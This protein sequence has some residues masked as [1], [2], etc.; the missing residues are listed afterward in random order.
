[1]AIKLSKNNLCVN[2]IVGQKTEKIVVEGDE[3]VP[4]IKPDILSVV[5]TNGNICIYKKEVQDGK[6]KI[7]G[8]INAYVIYIADDEKSSIRALSANLE[9]SRTIDIKECKEN[10]QLEC[11]SQ[12]SNM[13]CRILNGRKISLRAIMDMSVVLYSKENIEYIDKIEDIN[14]IQLLNKNITIN[15]LVGTGITKVYA[16]DKLYRQENYFGLFY[17]VGGVSGV[18]EICRYGVV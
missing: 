13:D 17:L 10:M 15:S 16:K 2:Q 3:I 5:S 8:G 4:D 11:K 14:D 9:F 1:M 12:L 6:V 7:E 18:L